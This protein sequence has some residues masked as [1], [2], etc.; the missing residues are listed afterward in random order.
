MPIGYCSF[1]YYYAPPQKKLK[2]YFIF[3]GIITFS[4]AGPMK[5][6]PGLLIKHPGHNEMKLQGKE[7]PA[8]K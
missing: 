2:G 1:Y 4:L 7:V 5:C 6:N 3:N 8:P